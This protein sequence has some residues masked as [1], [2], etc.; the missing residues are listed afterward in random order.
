MEN[1]LVTLSLTFEPPS[2]L[3]PLLQSSVSISLSTDSFSERQ[4]F[5]FIFGPFPIT[6][7]PSPLSFTFYHN[8]SEFG[9]SSIS[10]PSLSIQQDSFTISL[11][12][13]DKTAPQLNQIQKFTLALVP[14]N[15]ASNYIN[16]SICHDIA[17]NIQELIRNPKEFSIKQVENL[18][19]LII[20]LN[21]KLKSLILLQQR[22][23]SLEAFSLQSVLKREE[24]HA[25]ALQT[26]E[27]LDRH[28]DSVSEK[29]KEMNK[30]REDLQLELNQVSMK[31]RDKCV[32]EERLNGE[33]RIKEAEIDK[34]KG[35]IR[36][37]EDMEKFI[38]NLQ[39]EAKT[40]EQER[41]ALREQYK[42]SINTFTEDLAARDLEIFNRDEEILR[43]SEIITSKDLEILN[44]TSESSQKSAQ[45]LSLQ[46]SVVELTQVIA[47]YKDLESKCKSLEA[48][49]KSHQSECV[50]LQSTVSQNL[51]DYKSSISLLSQEKD[52]SL[53]TI[54][55]LQT[56][57]QKL[58]TDLN[59]KL[60][61]Y[62]SEQIISQE[63]R[64]KSAI[65]QQK[66]CNTLDLSKLFT[67]VKYLS[68][69]MTELRD[70]LVEDNDELVRQV[71]QIT[72]DY[73]NAGKVIQQVRDIIE[74]RDNEINILRDLIAELQNKTIYYPIKDDPVDEAIADYLNL[75][76]EPLPVTFIREE[77]GIYLFGT[78]RVF[79]KL[80]NNR[81]IS[82]E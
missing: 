4:N 25:Q 35:Q 48:L 67:Q 12:N 37:F 59:E 20:G 21:S 79:I 30:A 68:G 47:S 60:A 18:R 40:L 61:L 7:L 54:S 3:D 75:R 24:T 33:L 71:L 57:M 64:S 19:T 50:A 28:N 22:V 26:C 45:I 14:S 23:G 41:A 78:K 56:E 62:R 82:K 73:L 58:S 29:F 81:I 51:S 17:L 74:D 11:S 42:S 13:P 2:A 46:S 10:L 44:L 9:S 80:E 72:E 53:Q 6:V 38:R 63:L 27:K 70:K 39:E 8:S 49:S 16:S 1:Q 31:F 77:Y 15:P 69:Q 32:E 5:P 55:S 43:L 65:I 34:L 36:N 66:L 76:S 52:S